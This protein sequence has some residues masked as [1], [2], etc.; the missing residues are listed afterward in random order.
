MDH[1]FNKLINMWLSQIPYDH[2]LFAQ[3]ALCIRYSMGDSFFKSIFHELFIV[4]LDSIVQQYL[5]IT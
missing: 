4:P 5:P 2:D 3:L 1:T